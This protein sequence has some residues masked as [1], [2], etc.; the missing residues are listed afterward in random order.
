MPTFQDKKKIAK[1]DEH[2]SQTENKL[3]KGK[4]G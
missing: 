3:I 1:D 2:F 4:E